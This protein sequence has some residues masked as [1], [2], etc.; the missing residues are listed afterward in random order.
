MDTEVNA[1]WG[2]WAWSTVSS[3]LPVD[4]DNSWS[5]DQI[6]QSGHTIHFGFFIDDATITFKVFIKIHFVS[7]NL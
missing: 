7:Q 1:T 3:I 6:I 5:N 2:T 4:W